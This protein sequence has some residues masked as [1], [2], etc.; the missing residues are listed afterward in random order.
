L[1][2]FSAASA[3]IHALALAKSAARKAFRIDSAFVIGVEYERS[4]SKN[5]TSPV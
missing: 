3:G 2:E 4:H 5:H 1:S